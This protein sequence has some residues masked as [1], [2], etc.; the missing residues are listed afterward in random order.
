MK[1][2]KITVT[3]LSLIILAACSTENNSDKQ[4]SNTKIDNFKLDLSGMDFGDDFLVDTYDFGLDNR[5]ELNQLLEDFYNFAMSE[6]FLEIED[7]F[8]IAMTISQSKTTTQPMDFSSIKES[9]LKVLG[10][11]SHK[12]C[13]KELIENHLKNSKDFLKN[14]ANS[15]TIFINKVKGKIKKISFINN[16]SKK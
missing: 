7:N 5:E 3:L 6:E 4:S 12:N 15:T 14:E 2:L 10:A 9:E 16:F 13:A 8:A 1:Q 11:C